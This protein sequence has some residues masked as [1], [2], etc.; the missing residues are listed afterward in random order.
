MRN[1]LIH[2]YYD[3]NRDILWQ[4]VAED[5]PPLIQQLEAALPAK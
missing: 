1:R 4:T 5:L 3:I 2:A